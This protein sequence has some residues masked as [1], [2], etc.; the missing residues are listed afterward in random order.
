MGG[1]PRTGAPPVNEPTSA[2]P[3][4]PV[5]APS[6]PSPWAVLRPFVAVSLLVVALGTPLDE[7]WMRVAALAAVAGVVVCLWPPREAPDGVPGRLVLGVGALFAV[8]GPIAYA[9]PWFGVDANDWPWT[10]WAES[11]RWVDRV[12]LVLWAVCALLGFVAARARSRAPAIVAVT[13]VVLLAARGFAERG[14]LSLVRMERVNLIWTLAAGTLGG[15]MMHLATAR[16]RGRGVAR[17]LALVAVAAITT[18]YAAWFPHDGA[19]SSLVHYAE[20]LP[21]IFEAA[22]RSAELSPEHTERMVQQTWLVAAPF[23]MQALAVALALVVILLPSRVRA[24]P[25]RFLAALSVVAMIA[26]WLIPARGVLWLTRDTGA[27]LRETRYA[28]SVGEVLMKAGLSVY[29]LLAGSVLAL[30]GR[31]AAAPAAAVEPGRRP[32]VWPYVAAAVLGAFVLWVSIDPAYGIET[33]ATFADVLRGARWDVTF[34]RFTYRAAIVLAALVAIAVR[35][36]R[37]AGGLGAAVAVVALGALTP[38]TAR[39]LG[40]ETY[41]AWAA[42]AS[43]AAAATQV[44]RPTARA[45]AAGAA[46]VALVLLLYPQPVPTDV[47]PDGVIQVPFRTA[48]VDD[49]LVPLYEVLVVESSATFGE[50]LAA[51]GR[52]AALGLA[53]T[54]LFALVAAAGRWVG[55]GRAALAAFAV[56]ALAGPVVTQVAGFGGGG[57]PADV[58][59]ALLRTG[60]V[61]LVWSI[62]TLLLLVGSVRDLLA[63]R[64]APPGPAQQGDDLDGPRP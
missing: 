59:A 61:L 2:A 4:L 39:W 24:R 36:P 27:G 62:P 19:R 63:P 51:P 57:P 15:A 9:N 58:G 50:V 1:V 20:D 49:T 3:P 33:T 34:A 53:V 5:G 13:L 60:E 16:E 56:L 52:L 55:M 64:L 14:A 42:T 6:A 54:V 21:P 11:R 32:A 29:L 25:L 28:Q 37:V 10:Y 30:L 7:P 43:A 41:V 17:W 48:L 23:L 45:L 12:D 31:P 46:L 22:F 26:T 18:V 35:S 47:R 8:L 44:R 38:S 40:V